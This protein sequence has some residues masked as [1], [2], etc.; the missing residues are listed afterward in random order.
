KFV[1]PGPSSIFRPASP[2]LPNGGKANASV[3]NHLSGVPSEISGRPTTFGR[4]L[5][6]KPSVDLPVLLLSISDNK[7]TV[8]G[9]PLCRVRMPNVCQPVRIV[10]NQPSPATNDRPLPNGKS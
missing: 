8:N 7:A 9:R 5:A 1:Y 6:P 10:G 3:L 4:S 2:K